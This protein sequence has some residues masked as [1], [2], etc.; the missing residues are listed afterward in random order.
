MITTSHILRRLLLTI[1]MRDIAIAM[2]GA[3]LFCAGL[4]SSEIS[5]LLV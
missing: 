1:H 3:I 5:W 2:G 4:W